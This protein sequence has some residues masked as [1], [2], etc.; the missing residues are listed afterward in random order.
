MKL[1]PSGAMEK[2]GGYNPQQVKMAKGKPA[3]LKA[4]PELAEPLYGQIRFG[5]KTHIIVLDEPAGG[6]AKLYVD[7]NGNGD[8]TDDPETKWEKKTVPGPNGVQLTQYSG[9]FQL[10]LGGGAG[11]EKSEIVSLGAY[12]FDP[13]DPQRA[14][15]KTTFLYYTD[16]AYEGEVTLGGVKHKAML[17]DDH[18]S[19]QFSATAGK[20]GSRLLIDVNGD[21]NFTPRGEMFEPGKPFNIKGTTW[22]LAFPGQGGAPFAVAVSSRKVPEIALP[23]NHSVG[24]TIT[25]FKARRMDGKAV[26][27]PADYKGKIVL[28][29]FWATWCPPC[30]AE[31]PGLV[32][33]YNTYHP[34]GVE[35]LG[36]SLDQP[37]AANRIKEVAKEHG[38]SWPH[39]YDGKFWKA[40]I[41]QRYGINSI[42]AAF[43]VDGDTGKIVATGGSLRGG[44]LEATLQ[45]AVEKKKS[46]G[47]AGLAK[48][49]Q[50]ADGGKPAAAEEAAA[51]SEPAAPAEPPAAP[52]EEPAPPKPQANDALPF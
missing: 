12:R 31:L 24:A 6:D 49:Q 34:Q 9:S 16:Y 11:D 30:M 33:A 40:D 21:G 26:D 47:D 17:A 4:A 29:D 5:G 32:Q 25:A 14:Q 23:P 7:A 48:A 15:L 18:A 36:I 43:L 45:A 41:A 28:L 22:Q 2:L 39:V 38:M 3:A 44:Q 27:F 10:P 52:K 1:L 50:K 42:P 46:P 20:E 13:N 37:N 8:L 35:I 19:G 51:S